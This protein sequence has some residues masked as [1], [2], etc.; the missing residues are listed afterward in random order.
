[1]DAYTWID[2]RDK[3]FRE[4]ARQ[5]QEM[6]AEDFAFQRHVRDVPVRESAKEV[7]IHLKDFCKEL[8]IVTSYAIRNLGRE[9]TT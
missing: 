4:T 8:E 6:L 3:L 2:K 7:A 9:Q 1:M 5:L